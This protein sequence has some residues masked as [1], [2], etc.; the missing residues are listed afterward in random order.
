LYGFDSRSREEVMTVDPKD[1]DGAI[2]A[3]SKDKLDQDRGLEL[4]VGVV[5]FQAMDGRERG[6]R[7]W[8]KETEGSEER[9]REKTR[10]EERKQVTD[11]CDII[12]MRRGR[13]VLIAV[14]IMAATTPLNRK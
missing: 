2:D 5:L 6:G 3:T 11:F 1:E 14:M 9:G 12:L 7:G 8:G 10:A 4:A 13:A